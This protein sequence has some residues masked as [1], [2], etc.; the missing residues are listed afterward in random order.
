MIQVRWDCS[1]RCNTV[2]T[3]IEANA[4]R[5]FRTERYSLYIMDELVREGFRTLTISFDVA[6]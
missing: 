6:Q 3:T 2:L 5:P 4:S 1:D